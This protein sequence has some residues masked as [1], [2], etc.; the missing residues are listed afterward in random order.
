METWNLTVWCLPVTPA[1]ALPPP[2]LPEET[3]DGFPELS[4]HSPPRAPISTQ[5][6]PRRNSTTVQ[7]PCPG[8]HASSSPQEKPTYS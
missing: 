4:F 7:E 6:V 2:H 8:P 1:G 5:K 3:A